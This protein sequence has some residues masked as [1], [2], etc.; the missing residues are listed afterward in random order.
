MSTEGGHGK[1]RHGKDEGSVETLF[2]NICKDLQAQNGPCYFGG[3]DIVGACLLW[4]KQHSFTLDHWD[5]GTSTVHCWVK[6]M[7]WLT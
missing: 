5:L 2:A 4:V 3:V 1:F 7:C 6:Q